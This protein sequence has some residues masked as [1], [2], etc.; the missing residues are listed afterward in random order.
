MRAP[1]SGLACAELLAQR[2]QARHLGLGDLD[3]LA[4]EV[5]EGDVLD[6]VV[7]AIAANPSPMCR[8][9]HSVVTAATQ[10]RQR[11]ALDNR[12]GLSLPRLPGSAEATTVAARAWQRMLSGRGST[13]STRR[14]STSR[15]RTS[16]TASPSSRAG[17][18]RR[19]ASIPI[20]WPSIRCWSRSST[21]GS[22]RGPEPRWRLAALLHDAPEYVIGDMISPVKARGRAGLCRDGRAARRGGAP[23]L[24]AAGRAAGAG[25]GGD[26]AGRPRSRPGSRR[27]RSRAS[28]RPRRTGSS[29]RRRSRGSA[30][31]AIRLRPPSEVKADFL[32]RH[33]ELCNA[34]R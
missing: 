9:S 22:R 7:L 2:H 21:A 31:I 25:Q 18:G 32:A 13:C 14:R 5:G 11:R 20:R 30:A 16:P 6:D 3:L 27:C 29:G 33:A 8:A 19:A 24:R 12:G 26:Q 17:T 15:S 4:A 28:R 23:A 1:F 34:L 10:Q